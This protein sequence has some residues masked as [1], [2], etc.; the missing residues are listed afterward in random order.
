MEEKCK[1]CPARDVCGGSLKELANR[2]LPKYADVLA[3]IATS[4]LTGKMSSLDGIARAFVTGYVIRTMETVEE[5]P[6]DVDVWG[7]ILNL[8][9]ED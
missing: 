7:D 8:L 5:E 2:L 1:D 6:L 4:V 3:T 9:E